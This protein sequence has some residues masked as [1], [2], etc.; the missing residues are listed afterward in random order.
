M[1]FDAATLDRPAVHSSEPD[2]PVAKIV[3]AY[4]QYLK[5]KRA[6]WDLAGLV[7]AYVGPPG[8]AGAHNGASKKIKDLIARL[9]AVGEHDEVSF[10]WIE[11]LRTTASW[12]PAP[13]RLGADFLVHWAARDVETLKK[14]MA[15]A[16]RCKRKL[17]PEFVR[18]VANGGKKNNDHAKWI[19][20]N[21]KLKRA[22]ADRR[23]RC[24]PC[25]RSKT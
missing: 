4:A 19:I 6:I 10:S 11:R 9:N 15:E 1:T 7:L 8:K 22:A 5:H 21:D 2:D 20:A 23:H 3:A 18:E 24:S 13:N 25:C 12:F 16:K 14:A 17:T